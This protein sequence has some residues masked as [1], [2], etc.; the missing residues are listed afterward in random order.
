MKNY[1]LSNR[2]LL[3]ASLGLAASF[4]A[5]ALTTLGDADFP[6]AG[7][8]SSADALNIVAN[9][10]VINITSGAGLDSTTNHIDINAASTLTIKSTATGNYNSSTG[11]RVGAGGLTSNSD[12]NL[13]IKDGRGIYI[14]NSGLAQFNKKVDIRNTSTSANSFIGIMAY[15]TS[16]NGGSAT[17]ADEVSITSTGNDSYG[18]VAQIGNNPA[19][20]GADLTFNGKVTVDMQGTA[21]TGVNIQQLSGANPSAGSF[22]LFNNGLD[23]ATS[24]GT[25]VSA[26]QEGGIITINGDSSIVSRNTSGGA[27]NAIEAVMGTVKVDGKSTIEG[28]IEA[29]N[30]GVVD[31]NLHAG[32]NVTSMMDNYSVNVTSL[33][34]GYTPGKINVAMQTGA[35]WN[36][37]NDSY[38]DVLNGSGTVK[39]QTTAA[40]YGTLSVQD[41]SGSTTFVMRT[42]IVGDGAGNNQ[43]DLLRVTGTSAGN[44]ILNVLNNGSAQTNGT[45]ADRG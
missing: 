3:L 36:M 6:S 41:L 40:P 5:N 16:S 32:S 23:V 45:G 17:F 9:S 33:P 35:V 8:N 21:S 42:D 20:L 7:K 29:I 13:D 12:I 28:N 22:I 44:H 10:P 38:V 4:S 14:I 37:S 15:T 18:I 19:E 39:Y 30:T 26:E 43:G 1:T 11:I 31:L 24:N 34:A 25:A 2:F 27:Y